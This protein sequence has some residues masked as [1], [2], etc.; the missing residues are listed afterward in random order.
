MQAT[1]IA[2]KKSQATWVGNGIIQINLTNGV[3]LGED[4]VFRAI[5]MITHPDIAALVN[6]S[7]P[8]AEKRVKLF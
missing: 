4:K 3:Q 7:S 2:I 5:A 8:L 6:L 1:G